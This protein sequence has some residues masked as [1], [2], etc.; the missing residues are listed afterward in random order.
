M[1]KILIIL[2]FTILALDFRGQVEGGGLFQ[3]LIV[4]ISCALGA[5]LVLVN[6]QALT[7]LPQNTRRISFMLF[8]VVAISGLVFLKNSLV[9]D[10]YIRVVI[11]VVISAFSFSAVATVVRN[12]KDVNFIV[13]VLIGTAVLSAI[14]RFYYSSQV[15]GISLN[16]ARYQILSAGTSFLLAYS[17]YRVFLGGS[18][19]WFPFWIGI[20]LASLSVIFLSITRSYLLAVLVVLVA[21]TWVFFVAG[22]GAWRSS[23]RVRFISSIAAISLIAV[24]AVVPVMLVFRP[25]VLDSWTSRMFETKGANAA[26]DPTAGIRIAQVIGQVE[27]FRG[28]EIDILFGRGFG[29]FFTM[30]REFILQYATPDTMREED[31]VRMG[32]R[33]WQNPDTTYVPVLF[34]GGLFF[35][36]LVFYMFY[37][38]LKPL[39]YINRITDRWVLDTY[40]PLAFC[41]LFFFVTGWFGNLLLDR[42][43]AA[44]FGALIALILFMVNN[45]PA[46]RGHRTFVAGLNPGQA[47]ISNPALRQRNKGALSPRSL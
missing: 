46:L 3:L 30:N 22:A 20:F 8:A 17:I 42:Y 26:V 45:T 7:Q 15:V 2:F 28:N 36:F 13:R 5:A 25:D 19:L 21:S 18:K 33:L 24:F 43:G 40:V 4:V 12:Y 6:F 47:V 35:L 10:S 39:I 29:A 41:V 34:S 27:E 11:P 38:A 31:I 32:M 1:S 16:D 44:L 14:W 9:F 37:L 23:L